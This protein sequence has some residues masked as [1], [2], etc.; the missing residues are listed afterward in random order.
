MNKNENEL[1]QGKLFGSSASPISDFQSLS[2]GDI[3]HKLAVPNDR[4]RHLRSFGGSTGNGS[5]PFRV[6]LD[7]ATKRAHK[8]ARRAG[9][10][11]TWAKARA[12]A[13]RWCLDMGWA[14][15]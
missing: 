13:Y 10:R 6:R 11:I 15:A 5:H 9:A 8:A 2:L 1:M 12:L 14:P 4:V 3:G 7:Q